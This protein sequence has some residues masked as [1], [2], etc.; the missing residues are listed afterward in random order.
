MKPVI[1]PINL[2]GVNCYL[3][4][5]EEGFVLIDTGFS[6]K[7]AILD[8]KLNEAGVLPGSIKLI[9]IT[10]GDTDHTGNAAYLRAKYG[11]K[12]AM[13][14]DDAGMAEQGDMSVNRKPRPDR[15]SLIFKIMSS[16]IPLFIKAAKFEGF[17]PDLAAD[18]NIDLAAYGLDARVL[19]LPG[20]SKG[21]IGVLTAVGDLFCGDFLY[22]MPGFGFIDDLADHR[23]SLEK[24]KKLNFRTIY[25]G[26]G[27]PFSADRFRLH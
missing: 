13:H 14:A 25:P 20:H 27:K 16:V 4:R 18:E 21:S 2:G 6:N 12:I 1:T 19:H 11:A 10:H 22:N 7:R 23:A 9:L 24:V 8:K 17:K 26:H 5:G 3:L 15:M